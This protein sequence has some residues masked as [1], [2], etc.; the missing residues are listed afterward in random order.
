[1]KNSEETIAK[2][3]AGLRDGEQAVGMESRILQGLQA[4]AAQR[5][6]PGWRSFMPLWT[7]GR[8]PGAAVLSFS[9][10]VGLTIVICIAVLTH[11]PLQI[12][13][14]SPNSARAVRSAAIAAPAVVVESPQLRPRGTRARPKETMAS[15]E[16][17]RRHNKS[18]SSPSTQA[19]SHPA[20]PLPLTRQERL[21]LHV[22]R[23]VDPTQLAILN[24]GLQ[25]MQ[26]AKEKYEFE[27]FF[28]LTTMRGN[29]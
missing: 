13:A 8:T 15:L 21:L 12:R 23:R 11:H 1:M 20:P 10:A 22:V 26:D 18:P 17:N 2:V 19:V 29:E 5:T 9:C 6:A 4:R 24:P 7:V 25:A 16:R 3:M 14:H 27:N 28:G